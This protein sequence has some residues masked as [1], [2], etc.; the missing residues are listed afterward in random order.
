MQSKKERIDKIQR[1]QEEVRGYSLILSSIDWPVLR[2][3]VYHDS[4][5]I[6]RR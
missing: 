1:H 3:D 2:P 5:G 6:E 4:L